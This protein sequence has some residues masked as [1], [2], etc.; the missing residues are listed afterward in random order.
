MYIADKVRILECIVAV[1]V[2]IYSSESFDDECKG[3]E[4]IE[5]IKNK[6]RNRMSMLEGVYP[7]SRKWVLNI[8]RMNEED[9]PKEDG[10]WGPDGKEDLRDVLRKLQR[11]KSDLE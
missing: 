3:N 11:I 6:F 7:S 10:G 9:S 1:S 5:G 2:Y 4:I 8:E